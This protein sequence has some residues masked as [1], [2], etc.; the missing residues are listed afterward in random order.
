[1]R[2][3]TQALLGIVVT[4]VGVT[5]ALIP[6]MQKAGPLPEFLDWL[7][8]TLQRIRTRWQRRHPCSL[9]L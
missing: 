8:K 9:R 5:F 1:M 2:R 4:S 7:I 6:E 3:S